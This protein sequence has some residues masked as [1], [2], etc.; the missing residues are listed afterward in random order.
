MELVLLWEE[1]VS[2]WILRPKGT[3]SKEIKGTDSRNKLVVRM[4]YGQWLPLSQMVWVGR[5]EHEMREK[6]L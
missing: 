2:I 3:R 1:G 6:K 4:I 5:M